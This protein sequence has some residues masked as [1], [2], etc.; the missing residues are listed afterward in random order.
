ME[1]VR[2]MRNGYLASCGLNVPRL[3]NV[4]RT[5]D[6]AVE[7]RQIVERFSAETGHRPAVCGPASTPARS[8]RVWLAAPAVVYD[9]WGSAV[10]L[11]HQVAARPART[12]NLRDVRGLRRH[13]GRRSS[14]RRGR[15]HGGHRAGCRTEPIWRLVERRLMAYVFGRVVVLLGRRYR[16]RSA[17]SAGRAHRDRS[18]ALR[19]A[20][21]LP[22][23]A[24][25]DCCAPTSCRWA[26]CLLSDDQ[27][28]PGTRPRDRRCGS[29]PPSSASSCWCCCSRG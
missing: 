4:R 13:A 29:S 10:N 25:S 7:M 11:A 23:Q 18:N 1:R 21:Q 8:P 2:T 19:R 26:R 6:F 28:P 3:D 12:G 27:G 15:R 22:G 5:V 24:G 17:G 16:G 20:Q 14:S 9:M